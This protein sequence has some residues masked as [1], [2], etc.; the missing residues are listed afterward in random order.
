MGAQ[1][2][3][4][5]ANTFISVS[6]QE[7]GMIDDSFTTD[8][9][10]NKTWSC[11]SPQTMIQEAEESNAKAAG[12]HQEGDATCE[13]IHGNVDDRSV[14]TDLAPRGISLA[15]CLQQDEALQNSVAHCAMVALA[16]PGPV[17]AQHANF[18][19]CSSSQ[20]RSTWTSRMVRNLPND[21]RRQDVLDFLDSMGVNYD[22]IYVPMDWGRRANLGYAFVNLISPAEAVRI[23]SVLS[24]FS[25]WRTSSEKTCEV[26]WGQ[27]DQ[28]SLLSNVERFRNSPVMH[29]DVPDEFKPML[30]TLGRRSAFPPPTKRI[31]P[32]REFQRRLTAQ[33][34]A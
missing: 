23:E 8:P 22:F 6:T 19:A 16:Q 12:L 11:S 31:R 28:Q 30:F 17:L 4:H 15:A 20:D 24:G 25:G 34:G 5:T 2:S 18:V 10:M 3:G 32:P 14:L 33:A 21:Y 27:V 7:R 26:V 1:Q 29:P 13:S 9:R